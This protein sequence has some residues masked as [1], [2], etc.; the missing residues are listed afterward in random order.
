MIT[1]RILPVDEWDKVK[2][3]PPYNETGLPLPDGHWAIIVVEDG[4]EILASCALFDTVHWDG[5]HV[6]PSMRKNPVVFRALLEQSLSELQASGVAGAHI[7]IPEDS[8]DLEAMVEAFGFVRA[9]GVLYL[10]A[11]PPRK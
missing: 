7:T 2:D 3:R 6:N 1:S 9:P 4:E 8:P 10:P 5:F 11:V